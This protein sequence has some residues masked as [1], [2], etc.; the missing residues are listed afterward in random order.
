[1][2]LLMRRAG[3]MIR[4]NDAVTIQILKIGPEGVTF[5]INGL[6]TDPK[7]T[8]QKETTKEKEKS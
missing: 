7:K 6:A 8:E 4:I 1:M 3:E 2:L 5:E